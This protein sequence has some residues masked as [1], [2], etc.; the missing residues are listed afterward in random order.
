M[1]DQPFNHLGERPMSV[2]SACVPHWK[3]VISDSAMLWYMQKKTIGGQLCQSICWTKK[4]I[5]F[6]EKNTKRKKTLVDTMAH[7]GWLIDTP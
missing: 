1:C 3:R 5:L 7:K 6:P 4:Q 2:A